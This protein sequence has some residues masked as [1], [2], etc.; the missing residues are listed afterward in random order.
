M[1]QLEEGAQAT[2]ERTPE[3]KGK[4]RKPLFLLIPIL[5]IVLAA[6]LAISLFDKG[7]IGMDSRPLFY[8]TSRKEWHYRQGP[9]SMDIVIG[10][11]ASLQ[12]KMEYGFWTLDTYLMSDSGKAFL[13]IERMRSGGGTLYLKRLENSLFGSKEDQKGRRIDTE[14]VG[15]RFAPGKNDALYY[16]KA[17]DDPDRSTLYYYSVRKGSRRL[18]SNV[19]GFMVSED[20]KS[21]LLAKNY[22]SADGSFSLTILTPGNDE[23][24]KIASRVTRLE[25]IN[26]KDFA[27]ILYS[28][29]D[30]G[31][32]TSSLY[33]YE[34]ASG[35]AEELFSDIVY[36]YDT[37]GQGRYAISFKG[38]ALNGWS[39]VEDDRKEQDAAEYPAYFEIIREQDEDDGMDQELFKTVIDTFREMDE[40]T[41]RLFGVLF[42]LEEGYFGDLLEQETVD[43]DALREQYDS[44]L[45]KNNR[46]IIREMLDR[47]LPYQYNQTIQ[48]IENGKVVRELENAVVVDMDIQKGNLIVGMTTPPKKRKLSELSGKRYRYF[49]E[50][51][52]DM[53][54]E[55]RSVPEYGD[56]KFDSLYLIENFGEPRLLAEAPEGGY[57]Y[58]ADIET[59]RS[60]L[61]Y[62]QSRPVKGEEEAAWE[63]VIQE[64][65]PG[66][67]PLVTANFRGTILSVE[68]SRVYYLTEDDK[69]GKGEPGG[70]LSGEKGYNLYIRD[71]PGEER[72]LAEGVYYAFENGLAVDRGLHSTDAAGSIYYIE[73]NKNGN[74]ALMKYD[75]SKSTVIAEEVYSYYP[76]DEQYGEMYLAVGVSALG[77]KEEAGFAPIPR[78]SLV[79]CKDGAL[80]PIAEDIIDFGFAGS[81][82]LSG[83]QGEGG[84]TWARN[85]DG[86][87]NPEL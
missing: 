64:P 67:Q 54:L 24:V 56:W 52:E 13:Y 32:N 84:L 71:L 49:S 27:R 40:E 14:V 39:L 78:Y 68:K 34:R 58:S 41:E 10:K 70:P 5:A 1:M 11:G 47:D 83:Y 30:D 38:D 45:E 37:D 81:G 43:Y 55:Y 12:D 72:L 74:G 15:Y 85:L 42:G 8:M 3:I 51:L 17:G 44:W 4:K 20:G 23:K 75:G 61:A 65:L 59:D 82:H 29:R 46:D 33:R 31:N 60:L 62:V 69:G 50:L 73:G 86:P 22:D 18:D 28:K 80:T 35:S 2:L 16:L 87:E 57:I 6:A 48:L 79:H 21:I 66:A 9:D 19:W 36:L 25:A 77:G 26:R 63:L 76:V 7:M 53:E